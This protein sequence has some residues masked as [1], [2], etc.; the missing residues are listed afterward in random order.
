MEKR[1]Y[2]YLRQRWTKDEIKLKDNESKKLIHGKVLIIHILPVD[3]YT[4]IWDEGNYPNTP[5]LR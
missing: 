4:I 5:L 3:R 1:K 2:K